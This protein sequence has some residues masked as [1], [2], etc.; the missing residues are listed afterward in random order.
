MFNQIRKYCCLLGFILISS[1]GYSQKQF[2]ILIQFVPKLDSTEIVAFLDNGKGNKE[3]SVSVKN[4]K[5]IIKS[6]VYSRY[7]TLHLYS[8]TTSI[9][10]LYFITHVESSIIYSVNDKSAKNYPF[11]NSKLKNVLEIPYCQKMKSIIDYTRREREDQDDFYQKHQT[12]FKTNDSLKAIYKQKIIIN[13]KKNLEF[14]KLNSNQYFYL[15]FFQLAFR[16][17]IYSDYMDADSLLQFYKET[18]YPK[19]SIFFEAK[20]MLE[21]LKERSISQSIKINQPAPDF[22]T[23]DITGREFSLN[24]FRGKY[25]LLN[26]WATWCGPCVSEI[27]LLKKLREDFPEY[28]LEMI[29]VSVD[30]T[31]RDLENGIKKYGLNWTHVFKDMPLI[32]RY[33]ISSAVPLFFLIDKAGRLVF[34]HVGALSDT[35]EIRKLL[36][37]K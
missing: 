26:I 18:L 19:Y 13:A 20:Y 36:M 12:E 27:P 28:L 23:T 37:R 8:P 2:H 1:L 24:Q 17:S 30:N 16:N 5:I 9:N 31:K 22:T 25:V 14:I 35:N 21:Y 6:E 29:S 32:N 15:W 4:S 33:H 34:M 11:T 10:K 3:I 7:A